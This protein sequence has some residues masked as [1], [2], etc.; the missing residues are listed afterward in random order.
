MAALV[1]TFVLW[2][3]VQD[4]GPKQLLGGAIVLDGPGLF[5]TVV[6]CAAVILAALF[7]DGLPASGR[8]STASR[9]TR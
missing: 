5:I 2:S 8:S 1:V 6:I 3:Q 9:S 7:L 4:N